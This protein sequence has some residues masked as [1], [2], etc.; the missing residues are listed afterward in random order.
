[1]ENLQDINLFF[2]VGTY[3]FETDSCGWS[4][5]NN[6]VDELDWLW[7]LGNVPTRYTGSPIDHTTKTVRGFWSKKSISFDNLSDF[8]DTIYIEASG[9]TN[10]NG[11]KSGNGNTLNVYDENWICF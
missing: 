4:N 6:A 2:F 8:Q 10:E 1:M 11:S 7:S 3:D 5:Y 9:S